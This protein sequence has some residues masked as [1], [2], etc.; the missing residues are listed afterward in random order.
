M[1]RLAGVG[2]QA[3]ELDAL[4]GDVELRLVLTAHPT[5]A[6][7][8]TTVEK[9]GRVFAVLRDL[10]ERE[11]PPGAR[12]WRGGGCSAPSRSC[13]APTSCAPSRPRSRDEVHSGLVYFPRR[14]PVVPEI[15]RDLEEAIAV[16]YP[17]EDDRGAAV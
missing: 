5:E 3:G 13:G 7:R 10:D 1:Q 17:G 4:L 14:C 12:R 15:Y 11:G 16:R 8:R 2:V 6:R 9:L